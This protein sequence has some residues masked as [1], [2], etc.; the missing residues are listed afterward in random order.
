[1]SAQRFVRL[2][3]ILIV[4]FAVGTGMWAFLAPKSFYDNLAEFPPY[5]RHLFHDIGAFSVGMGMAVVFALA[6]WGSLRVALSAAAVGNVLHGISHIVDRD[7]GGRSTD[8]WSLS[9]VA[10]VTV[11]AAIAAAKTEGASEASSFR[12]SERQRA[13]R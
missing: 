2:V 4:V 11:A 3:C 13:A 10:I 8:P 1:M 9:F 12:A 7:L 5:N 6:R